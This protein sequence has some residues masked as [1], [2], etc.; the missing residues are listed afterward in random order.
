M[1]KNV[2]YPKDYLEQKITERNCDHFVVSKS[3]L[4]DG[5]Y[6]NYYDCLICGKHLVFSY[7]QNLDD[8]LHYIITTYGYLT[9]YTLEIYSD[10]I[11]KICLEYKDAKKVD[12]VTLLK[13]Y[14]PKID[15][16]IEQIEKKKRK[17][18]FEKENALIDLPTHTHFSDGE[19]SPNDL[20]R[21]A[22]NKGTGINDKVKI[23]KLSLLVH[24]KDD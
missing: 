13:E 14:K 7:N 2:F 6:G 20:L 17:K 9:P 12:I 10:Y 23:K 22:I 1:R 21:F 5:L 8:E 18:G 4:D 19:L 24:I 3:G 15:K 11:K 16:A